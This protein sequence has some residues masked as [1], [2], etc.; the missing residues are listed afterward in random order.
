MPQH[1]ARSRV[2]P[3]HSTGS[4][5]GLHLLIA[6]LLA[7]G[8][9][10]AMPLQAHAEDQ[11]ALRVTKGVTG[12]QDGHV[13]E[14]GE[15]FDYTITVA[16]DNNS[17]AGAGCTN[18]ALTDPLPEGISYTGGTIAVVPNVGTPSVDGDT[19]TVDFTQSLADPP[20]SQ[21]MAAGTTVTITI[22]VR[23]DPD[24]DPDLDGQD[25]TNTA[26]ADG[27][28]TNE[29]SDDFTVVPNIE[30]TLNASTDKSF[31]PSSA[32]A[33]PGTETT[34]TLTGGNASSSNV[35]ADEI[36]I[37]DPNDP[38]G[39]PGAFE[40]LA[41]TGEF[42]VTLPA[43]AEQVQ[44]DCYV[45]GAW[46]DGTPG[47]DASLPGSVDD[48]ADCEGV[49]IHFISTNG[50]NIA[51]GA[52]GS[53][54]VTLAQRD[55]IADAGDGPT[56][57][58]VGTIATNEDVTS[59]KVTAD[60]DYTIVSSDIDLAAHKSF[61]PE[62]IA[63]GS[64][65]TVTIGATNTSD[66]T[67]DTLTITEPGADP[68]MF[69]GDNP[70]TFTGWGDVQ[71]PSGATGATITYTYADGSTSGELTADGPDTLPDPAAGQTV[72]GFSVTFTGPIVPG[73]EA[74]L[75]FTVTADPNQTADSLAHPNTVSAHSTAPGGYE[76]DDD[77]TATLT[78]LAKRLAIETEKTT[79]PP[80]IFNSPGQLVLAELT[81]TVKD[82]PE[83]TTD[84]HQIIVQD[85]VN[86]DGTDEWYEYFTPAGVTNTP[87]PANSTMTVQYYNGTEWVDIEGMTDL[88]GPQ[89]FSGWFPDSVPDDAQGIRFVYESEDG[90]PPGT[91]V[92]PNLGFQ[93]KP[94]A[95]TESFSV[96]DCASSQASS[97][98]PIVDPAE[99]E[100]ACDDIT[101]VPPDPGSGDF[102]DKEWDNPATVA[103]RSQ[104]QKGAT[105]SWSTN[106]LTG[107]TQM[108]VSDVPN[109]SVADLPSSVFDSFDLVRI[110]P[111]T[112]ALDPRLQ[113]D[114]ITKLELYSRSA[115]GWVEPANDPCL[116]NGCDK[117]FPGYT[118]SA[119]QR[120]DVIGFRLTYVESPNRVAN[121]A[122]APPIGSGV[123]VSS[124]NNR[125]IHPVF[126]IRDD[127]RSDPNTPVLAE[128]E[129]NIDGEEGLVRNDVSAT[130]TFNGSDYSQTDSDNIAITEVNVT[131]DITKDWTGGPLGV[132]APGSAAFPAEYPTA[133]VALTGTNTT[134]A[135]VDRLTIS[136]ATGDTDP[137]EDFNLVGFT[138][139]TEPSAIGATDVTIT[140][141]RSNGNRDEFTRDEALALTEDQLTDAVGFEVAYE[142]RIDAGAEADVT[143]DTR[144]RDFTRSSNGATPVSTPQTVPNEATVL[145]QDLVDYPDTPNRESDDT[146]EDDIDLT[147]AGIG[148]E[149]TKTINPATQTEPD[150]SPVNVTLT[151]RP[152]GP[153]ARSR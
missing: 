83:S 68:N 42:D 9:I 117:Q 53:I 115:N 79:R 36:V 66:L 100:P 50:A 112:P 109:P 28:N 126:E 1:P 144:V 31:D 116:N 133:T 107:V 101:I 54:D 58:E 10:L 48:P 63:A 122:D 89:I 26:T 96:Q 64:D 97:T 4:R 88:A 47:A 67:L 120:E 81:G 52:S 91:E 29:A 80:Q 82:F 76:G 129:Y 150:R 105:L 113:Y 17:A 60:D 6:L 104:Q 147:G 140:V 57:N 23:V 139:I 114:Q 32:V 134:P 145:V 12:W 30:A 92:N 20:N 27:S 38:P 106:G 14:P 65:S 85:P 74:S 131:S 86:L 142:G 136:D 99:G 46:V 102:I 125:K 146:A 84:A 78:T 95:D 98:D 108:V 40:Y 15:T 137:F 44:I 148:L 43:G 61:D 151:G 39:P 110:D 25:L 22:P 143:F 55:N 41:V 138:E 72:T 132:P 111:I 70:V 93:L 24:I 56:T 45:D 7:L 73:A 5:R 87:I 2:M 152:T 19:V 123:A 8:G 3:S 51:P 119:E 103:E 90:F 13:V 141:I 69:T 59:S 149:V 16:C 77:A 49:R 35:P 118:L 124:G 130:G 121:A 62:T 37:T 21:G 75:P 128:D 135:K 71:W 153:R 11:G 18:A 94:N 33:N 34:M 127:L